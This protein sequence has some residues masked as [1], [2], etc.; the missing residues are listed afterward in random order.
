VLSRIR[1]IREERYSLFRGFYHGATDAADAADNLQPRL[2]SVVLTERSAAVGHTLEELD[3]RGRVEVTGVRRRGARS[4]VPEPDYRF[5]A[6]D[7]VVLL[8]VPESLA[9]AERRLLHE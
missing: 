6:G 3:L 9:V 7:I 8:G 5:E 1:A 2:H 4:V